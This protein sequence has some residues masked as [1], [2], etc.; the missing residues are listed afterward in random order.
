MPAWPV[1]SYPPNGYGLYD[2]A[3]NAWEWVSD[4]YRPDY[5]RRLRA[6]ESRRNPQGPDDR[7]DSAEPGEKKPRPPGGLVPLHRIST[8]PGTWSHPAGKGEVSTG[9]NHVGFRCVKS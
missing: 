4:W 5:Y 8:A 1:G 7:S 6:P 3:G 2:I 9:T